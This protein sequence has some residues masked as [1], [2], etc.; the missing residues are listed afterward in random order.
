MQHGAAAGLTSV[1]ELTEVNCLS[2]WHRLQVEQ[3]AVDAEGED[4]EKARFINAILKVCC[5]S[6]T[7][8]CSGSALQPGQLQSPEGGCHHSNVS[9]TYN[10]HS[11]SHLA[12]S[13]Y[14]RRHTLACSM[15]T[16][17]L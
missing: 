11:P 10:L 16:S 12:V 7:R 17:S 2:P 13:T 5:L 8:L 14:P 3:K 15:R 9:S 1:R 4:A 6:L